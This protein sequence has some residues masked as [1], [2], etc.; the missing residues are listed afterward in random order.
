MS[1]FIDLTGQKFG[2]LTVIKRD[3]TR[4][5]VMWLC[6][7]DCGNVKSVRPYDLKSGATKSCGCY[8]KEINTK[9]GFSQTRIYNIWKGIIRRC[10]CPKDKDY[11]RYGAV[12]K[13]VC[14]E[15]L[16]DD[17]A[18]RF[19]EWAVAHGY[20]D[21]LTIDRIDNSKGYNPENCHW[22]DVKSQANNRKNNRLITYNGET[23][24]VQEWA[25]IKGIKHSCLLYRLNH[26]GV[27]KSL[28][29]AVQKHTKSTP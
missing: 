20:S 13:G 29:T 2:K 7:C 16:G 24:T 12:G 19:I 3:T 10:T 9:H 17:G 22:V 27:E 26:W 25:E 18:K 5:T 11:A 6:K 14:S 23:H 1:R 28:E 4:K 21:G 8:M 15:W